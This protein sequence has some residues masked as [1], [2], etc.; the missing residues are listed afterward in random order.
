MNKLLKLIKAFKSKCSAALKF[1]TP[2][3]KKCKNKLL[4]WIDIAMYKIAGCDKTMLDE[5]DCRGS[6]AVFR[7][8][9]VI[10][11]IVVLTAYLWVI[12]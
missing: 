2:A 1:V 8:L 11:V 7:D 5:L 6:F 9:L 10:G 4:D 3:I 12:L